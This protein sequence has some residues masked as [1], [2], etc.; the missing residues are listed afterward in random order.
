MKILQW[1]MRYT[2]CRIVGH[3]PSRYG[4]MMPAM[5]PLLPEEMPPSY[6]IDCERCGQPLYDYISGE[7]FE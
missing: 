3:K 2:I 6:I 7:K 4:L 1:I 5:V